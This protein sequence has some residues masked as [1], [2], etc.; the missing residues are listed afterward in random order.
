L[1]DLIYKVGV[2]EYVPKEWG[3]R[4]NELREYVNVNKEFP[5]RSSTDPDVKSLGEWRNHQQQNYKN[6][7]KSMKIGAAMREAWSDFMDEFP[8][9]FLSNDEKWNKKL[10]QLREYLTAN[11]KF[12]SEESTDP[13]VK[14]LGEWRSTQQYNYKNEKKNMIVGAVI[15]DDWGDFM[16]EFPELFI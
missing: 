1:A 5:S 11:D 6:E 8:E 16:D 15:R 4:F 2:R 13:D 9:L 7:K 14:S 10:L 3:E 12:P